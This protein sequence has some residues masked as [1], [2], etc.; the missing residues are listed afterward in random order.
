MTG[1]RILGVPAVVLIALA[2][3]VAIG[4]ILRGFATGREIYAIGSNPDGAALIGTRTTLLVLSV[5]AAAGLLAGLTARSGPRDMR[6]PTPA[7]PWVSS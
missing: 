5:V 6:R 4:A 7:S 2:A 1:A 3:L